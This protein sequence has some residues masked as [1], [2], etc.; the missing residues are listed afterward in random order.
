MLLVE[1]T[2]CWSVWLQCRRVES[3]ETLQSSEVF[4]VSEPLSPEGA[5]R[6]VAP[7]EGRQPGSSLQLEDDLLA[8]GIPDWA[9]EVE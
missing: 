1:G 7:M 5:W 4:P 9:L 3:R 6:G 8:I 2:A